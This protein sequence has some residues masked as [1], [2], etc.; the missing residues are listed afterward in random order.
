[1]TTYMR[2]NLR[3]LV[4]ENLVVLF[5]GMLEVLLPMQG[6]FRLPVFI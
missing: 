5:N 1:M 4:F 2:G 6:Y 3:K